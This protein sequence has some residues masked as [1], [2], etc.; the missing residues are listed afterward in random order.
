VG[1]TPTKR[2]NQRLNTRLAQIAFH[3]YPIP[4]D[5][6]IPTRKAYHLFF[7]PL[8]EVVGRYTLAAS[9]TDT[10]QWYGFF[11]RPCSK[12]QHSCVLIMMMAPNATRQA[13]LKAEARHE[14][15]L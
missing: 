9:I 7:F 14:R 6:T 10:R 5:R 15:R 13:R 1:D 11:D 4:E 2:A 8:D 12:S 3:L